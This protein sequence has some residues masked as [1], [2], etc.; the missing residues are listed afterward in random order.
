MTRCAIT[1]FDGD[2]I[3]LDFWLLLYEK[4]WKGEVDTIYADVCYDPTLVTP[5][6][7]GRQQK[8]LERFP[9]IKVEFIPEV[10][11]PEWS[12]PRLVKQTTEDNILLIES[13]G[14]IFGK[15]EVDK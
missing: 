4:Y 15:G 14:W 13:D 8:S 2:P 11:P 1:H 10:H 6:L 5:D 12:N 7:L 3:C 9:E